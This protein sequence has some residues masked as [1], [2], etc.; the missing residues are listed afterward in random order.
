M[1]CG[2]SSYRSGLGLD[3]PQVNAASV[4]GAEVSGNEHFVGLPGLPSARGFGTIFPV[5]G[6]PSDG[7]DLWNF[8]HIDSRL[9]QT[10][11]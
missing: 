9:S 7:P 4:E 10:I 8:D 6:L 2:G 11:A 5:L 1:Y 3:I